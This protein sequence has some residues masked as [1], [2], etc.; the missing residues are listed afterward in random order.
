[1]TTHAT[2]PRA[3]PIEPGEKVDDPFVLT[4]ADLDDLKK[5]PEP[6]KK[7]GN[8][9]ADFPE[10]S[11]V[12]AF[13]KH[14]VA[15]NGRP[16][17]YAPPAISGD[18]VPSDDE[19][20]E[21]ELREIHLVK[22]QSCGPPEH[23]AQVIDRLQV[24]IDEY[25]AKKAKVPAATMRE[26]A[27][28][29]AIHEQAAEAAEIRA[30]REAQWPLCRCLGVGGLGRDGKVAVGQYTD[31]TGTPVIVETW[32][33][34]CVCPAGQRVKAD[35]DAARAT[36]AADRQMRR[37]ARLRGEAHIPAKYA[38]L[39][40]STFPDQDVAVRA[41]NWLLHALDPRQKDPKLADAR[42]KSMLLVH[43]PNRRGKTGIAIGLQKLVL[44][45]QLLAIFCDVGDLMDEL[46][47]TYDK[48]NPLCHNELLDVLRKAPLLIFDDLGAEAW[49]GWVE[50]TLRKLINY[51]LNELLPTIFTTNLGWPDGATRYDPLI[52]KAAV[53]DRIWYRVEDGA[54]K[55]P[56]R[57]AILGLD[58]ATV[59]ALAPPNLDI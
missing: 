33:H 14:D 26:L 52:L 19:R 30:E 34:P 58:S 50:E 32:R 1:M 25:A 53:G 45:R 35:A 44:A 18:V 20:H 57:G 37:A 21:R 2:P 6:R 38:H 41:E 55:L 8:A 31:D 56:M 43:G 40:L 3:T 54:N 10:P 23:S 17:P 22:L 13:L 39:D 42:F 48:D 29:N 36:I 51:R 7:L 5:P 9:G 12:A 4:A 59:R 49:T 46:R 24:A 27:R 16:D 28:W 11:Q 47:A 15:R